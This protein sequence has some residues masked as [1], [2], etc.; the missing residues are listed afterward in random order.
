MA[1]KHVLIVGG[2][3]GGVK[4]A[5]ELADDDNFDITLIS[6]TN[7]FQY[8]PN[9]YRSATGGLIAESQIPFDDIFGTKRLSV[10]I[11]EAKTLDKKTHVLTTTNGQVYRYDI[12][13]LAL[14][15]VTN[16]FGIKGLAEFAYGT[17]SVDE[18]KRLKAHL[19]Q[20]LIDDQVPDQNYVI[21]GGGPTGIELAG[22]MT[23]Y[24]KKIMKN[25]GIQHHAIHI[26]LVEAAPRL[27]PRSP[28][29]MS[30]SVARRLKRLGI[31]LY[32]GQTVQGE[33][34]DDLKVNDRS[35]TSH[36][37]IW[38]AGMA[39]HPFFHENNFNFGM[40]GKVAVNVYMQA[41]D[42]IYILGDDANTPYSG[43]AQTALYDAKFV[44]R[45]LKR[46][47]REKS[48]KPYKPK[49]PITVIPAGT[50]WAVVQW[51]AIKFYGR[52]GWWLR[53]AADFLS[54]HDYEPWWQASE[55]FM[56]EFGVQ[57]D[58]PQC[59]VATNYFDKA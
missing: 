35:L 3:F 10:I 19:H 34:A 18:A 14:G 47:A 24:M 23:D 43:M 45:N 49:Q 11:G 44:A 42:D 1:K 22:A 9:L 21:V 30:R 59:Q 39:T 15:V 6:M 12:L 58:C 2:G 50:K 29:S 41:E 28:N 52:K 20:Q 38:T 51:G 48:L 53:E 25:H 46:Q 16:Y 8:Y 4:A 13:I 31:K 26:D 7:Y 57:E 40:H 54:F 37:V 56:T 55:Q 32:L 33:T 36:S 5:L 27:L 17:K